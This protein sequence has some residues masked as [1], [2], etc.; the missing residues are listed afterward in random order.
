MAA[1]RPLSPITLPPGCVAAGRGDR[2]VI[3][4]VEVALAAVGRRDGPAAG[5]ERGLGVVDAGADRHRAAVGRGV[6]FVGSG[7]TRETGERA[8]DLEHGALALPPVDASPKVVRDVV[9]VDERE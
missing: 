4:G 8:V 3:G 1:L 7:E 5:L 2:V 9:V 6:A